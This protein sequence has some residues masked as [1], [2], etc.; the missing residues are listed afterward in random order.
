MPKKPKTPEEIARDLISN[1]W[2]AGKWECLELEITHT[3]KAERDRAEAA[4]KERDEY[5]EELAGNMCSYC[6]RKLEEEGTVIFP[7]T[8]KHPTLPSAQKE[9]RDSNET[10]KTGL[11]DTYKPL[12]PPKCDSKTPSVPLISAPEKPSPAKVMCVCCHDNVVE[13]PI[14]HDCYTKEWPKPASLVPEGLERVECYYCQM[15]PYGNKDCRQCRGEGFVWV[16]V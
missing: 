16:R 1:Y 15:V 12:M 7:V 10:V 8:H 13:A 4:G 3:L 5:R 2:N 9:E 14:C 11:S 6:Y